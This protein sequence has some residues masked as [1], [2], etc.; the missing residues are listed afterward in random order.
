MSMS[1]RSIGLACSAP[2]AE[3]LARGG[4]RG[5]LAGRRTARTGP[6]RPA[7]RARR[8]RRRRPRRRRQLPGRRQPRPG[9]QR[10]RRTGD[11]CDATPN[12]PD[13][14]AD[15]VPD[16]GDNCPAA[17]N[18]D[19]ADADGDGVGD[20]CD[21]TERRRRR[22]R[23][24]QRGRHCVDVANPDQTDGDGDG[25]GDACD[26]A[27]TATPAPPT[28]TPQPTPTPSPPSDTPTPAPTP[29]P[30]PTWAPFADD[31]EDGDLRRWDRVE[32]LAVQSTEVLDGRF[33]ARATSTGSVRPTPRRRCPCR[34][35]TCT[36]A[37]GSSSMAD[38]PDPVYL[39]RLRAPDNASV[40]GLFLSRTRRW[41]CASTRPASG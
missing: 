39:V 32:G 22:R 16:A 14:D 2:L 34:S 36:S 4:D 33:A 24:R 3:P 7:G 29:T 1:S 27:P 8:R 20:A 31:F 38:N 17:P 21:A 11:A 18:P 5:P 25:T 28:A 23:G 19:Q 15:A 30:V 41:A 37:S 12:G 6:D 26:A 35:T 13:A 9:R 10:R 40:L